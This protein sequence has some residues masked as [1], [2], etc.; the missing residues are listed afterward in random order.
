MRSLLFNI[1]FGLISVSH[2]LWAVLGVP[3]DE[4]GADIHR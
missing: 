1:A 4:R 2:T 3:D